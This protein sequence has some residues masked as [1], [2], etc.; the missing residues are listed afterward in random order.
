MEDRIKKVLLY[1]MFFGKHSSTYCFNKCVSEYNT[2]EDLYNA[3]KKYSIPDI[4]NTI[5][6][7][8]SIV[9]FECWKEVFSALD[10][11]IEDE[12]RLV[13]EIFNTIARVKHFSP[14]KHQAAVSI[15]TNSPKINLFLTSI[16]IGSKPNI[17]IF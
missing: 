1:F 4:C 16:K 11:Q 14:S 17:S 2:P 3:F 5:W 13:V 12:K 6:N 7:R 8:I 10:V 9:R 15:F